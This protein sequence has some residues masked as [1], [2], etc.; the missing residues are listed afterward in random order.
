M[1]LWHY[2]QD[3]TYCFG[4]QKERPRHT[5]GSYNF[6]VAMLVGF[7]PYFLTFYPGVMVYDA[8]DAGPWTALQQSS[9]WI[10]TMDDHEAALGNRNRA[11]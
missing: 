1:L 2:Q 3:Q 11:V 8:D 10:H 6:F 5:D 9:S 4:T 7:V